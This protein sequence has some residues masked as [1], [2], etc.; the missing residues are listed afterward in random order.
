MFMINILLLV[1]V[2]LLIIAFV[3]IV[4]IYFKTKNIKME[5]VRGF[6]ILKELTS[7]YD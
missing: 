4:L 5:D 3:R 6:D 7:N 1:C 2:F